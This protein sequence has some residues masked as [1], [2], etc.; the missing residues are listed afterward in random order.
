MSALP[1]DF[2]EPALDFE[3]EAVEISQALQQEDS[4]QHEP[5][6]SIG[7]LMFSSVSLQFSRLNTLVL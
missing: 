6:P 7:L 4:I 1:S 5:C 2:E 3:P